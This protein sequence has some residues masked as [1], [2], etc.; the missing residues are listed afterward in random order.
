MIRV[1]LWGALL[2]VYTLASVLPGAVTTDAQLT[3]TRMPAFAAA[4]WLD[5]A[6]SFHLSEDAEVDAVFWIAKD[7]ERIEGSMRRHSLLLDAGVNEMRLSTLGKWMW[8][9]NLEPIED[10]RLYAQL[11][12]G[13]DITGLGPIKIDPESLGEQSPLDKLDSPVN[14]HLSRIQVHV[15][16]QGRTPGPLDIYISGADGAKSS[17]LLHL[18]EG[19]PPGE[20][21]QY[22]VYT[23]L[24]PSSSG[25]FHGIRGSSMKATE[26]SRS[27]V[28]P[29]ALLWLK[30]LEW[31]FSVSPTATGWTGYSDSPETITWY[32]TSYTELLKNHIGIEDPAP[33]LPHRIHR[34]R[35]ENSGSAAS[36][37]GWKLENLFRDPKSDAERSEPGK[38]HRGKARNLAGRLLRID[39]IISGNG[40]PGEDYVPSLILET[41]GARYIQR[42]FVY[43]QKEGDFYQLQAYF[44]PQ[45]HIAGVEEAIDFRFEVEFTG[46]RENIHVN[47][48]NLQVWETIMADLPADG[49]KRIDNEPWPM[50]RMLRLKPDG[51]EA[52]IEP[53]AS[54][55]GGEPEWNRY[56]LADHTMFLDEAG[57]WNLYGIFNSKKPFTPVENGA[58]LANA[59]FYSGLIHA[60]SCT[61][62]G[63]I[64]ETT[65]PT[66]PN[67]N[68]RGAR[69]DEQGRTSDVFV[70]R[71]QPLYFFGPWAPDV[72]QLGRI[73]V[74]FYTE[75]DLFHPR[76]LG[77]F[78]YATTQTPSDP[79]SW[80][81]WIPESP[82]HRLVY[83][84]REDARTRDLSITRRLTDAIEQFHAVWI[85]KKAGLPGGEDARA[86]KVLHK[87]VRDDPRLLYT[88]PEEEEYVIYD[89]ANADSG[90]I[91][92]DSESPSLIYDDET[93]IFYL[94]VTKNATLYPGSPFRN[95]MIV[96]D[97]EEER[98]VIADLASGDRSVL[99]AAGQNPVGFTS[100]QRF[101]WEPMWNYGQGASSYQ[102]LLAVANAGTK[103]QPP[104]ITLF[105]SLSGDS[106]HL[107][108]YSNQT[109]SLEKPTGITR[110]IMDKE[111]GTQIGLVVSDAG[112]GEKG[113]GFIYGAT[114]P[115]IGS[116]DER[117]STPHLAG[118]KRPFAPYFH[119]SEIRMGK[120]V[121]GVTNPRAMFAAKEGI[122]SDFAEFGSA[123]NG[124]AFIIRARRAGEKPTFAYGDI[125][126]RLQHPIQ[127]NEPLAVSHTPDGWP[128]GNICITLETDAKGRIVTTIEELATAVAEHKVAQ[129]LIEVEY[130]DEF[131]GG[132][133]DVETQLLSGGLDWRTLYFAT[134]DGIMAANLTHFLETSEPWI[135]ARAA[136][137]W[138]PAGLFY[139]DGSLYVLDAMTEA[140]YRVDATRGPVMVNRDNVLIDGI[141]GVLGM[142]YFGDDVHEEVTV[143]QPGR[144]SRFDWR[145]GA[146]ETVLSEDRGQGAW[147]GSPVG[148]FATTLVL[149]GIDAGSKVYW[150]RLDEKTGRLLP[151]TSKHYIGHLPF[152]ATELEFDTNQPGGS[153]KWFVSTPEPNR[154][155]HF[156]VRE[157]E[158]LPAMG[159]AYPQ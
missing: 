49:P 158:W 130:T 116:E 7:G 51:S 151:F 36:L 132:T 157:V 97:K 27:S 60:V 83:T 99:H 87:A 52:T 4:P 127:P 101:F 35:V 57:R 86:A 43:T 62:G 21:R 41:D 91:D 82:D 71:D 93:G 119:P 150:S 103:E 3:A 73:F 147:F 26:W 142:N 8:L 28:A 155:G 126:V 5:A 39:A 134:D 107:R 33:A 58:P 46:G 1:R 67:A 55:C 50:V 95:D 110:Y 154:G 144:V 24:P 139:R 37:G 20:S 102:F 38:Y 64:D 141:D 146:L 65:T 76:K 153:G 45:H 120:I 136:F 88:V 143:Y 114:L 63:A 70:D 47:L 19:P 10:Y 105:D 22:H 90:R 124:N 13:E 66:M 108:S 54:I 9:V 89:E 133:V 56:Y 17:T 12:S 84:N 15:G 135:V 96:L 122:E 85:G 11:T 68:Y 16:N 115:M 48:E 152:H 100:L 125:T 80:K 53:T 69:F 117:K 40:K 44:A 31:R 94:V 138:N 25:W 81:Q 104:A 111:D 77:G 113:S 109:P 112:S 34:L 30:T 159:A 32:S 74:M 78:G 23:A 148:A 75:H 156:A 137:A 123:E 29:D 106:V 121:D 79:M 14:G 140:L 72:V 128:E 42:P 129:A 18:D 131:A 2:L 98:I 59:P 6:I 61:P 92:S 149:E 118:G 145:A